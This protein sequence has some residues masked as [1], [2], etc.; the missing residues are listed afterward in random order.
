MNFWQNLKTPI[1]GLSPM[2]GVTDAAFR[3]IC[4]KHATPSVLIT[5]FTNVE[6]IARGAV[7]M[8]QAFIYHKIERPIVAQIYGVEVPSYYT[9]TLVLC[10]LG[11][12]G[13]DINMGCPANKVARRGSGA[14][15]I[16]TPQLAKDIVLICKKAVKDWEKGISLEKGG[17][18][19][20]IIIKAEEMRKEMDIGLPFHT[21]ND[22]TDIT[23]KSIPI[24]VKT[25]TGYDKIV[26]TEWMKHLLETEPANI[27]LHGRTLKQMY[28][29]ESNW[30]EI[31]KAAAIVRPTQTTFLGNGDI[32]SL[33]DADEKMKTYDI[34]GVLIGRAALG[35]PW[36]FNQNNYENNQVLPFQEKKEVIEE[37]CKYFEAH[38]STL[39]FSS[40]K[41]H[42]TW[43]CKGFSGAKELR[44]NLMRTKSFQE[45][46]QVL[47]NI[48]S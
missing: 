34:D 22:E 46:Y 17:V 19:P 9:L 30:E 29:G 43:Y 36:F 25:R 5:E 12:D 20:D 38:F 33:K 10:Y 40:I 1:I 14:A 4:A 11:Y 16:R 31:G 44:M 18:H 45:V 32:T 23:R 2:D 26:A 48:N 27:S 6:G 24:S 21:S 13:I 28:T 47:N 42:L 35:N 39:A 15:L 8:L 37:H 41:K 7:K 3:F